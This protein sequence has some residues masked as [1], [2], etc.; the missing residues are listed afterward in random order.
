[1]PAFDT[2]GPTPL[3][4]RL[5]IG[6]VRVTASDRADTLV[7]VAPADPGTGADVRAAERIEVTRTAD[8]ISV[9]APRSLSSLG[10]RN[11]GSVRVSVDLPAGSPVR[12]RTEIA[13]L[14]CEGDL[15]HCDLRTSI[16]DV[17]VERARGA[18]LASGNGTVRVDHVAGD[19]RLTGSDRVRVGRVEGAATVTGLNGGIEIGEVAGELAVTSANGHVHVGGA[20]GRA[21]IRSSNGTVRVDEVV[22]D[23][24][25]LRVGVGDIEVG[26]RRATA[27]W[28]DLD[29]R[30]GRVHRSLE[31][32][33]GPDGDERTVRVL[34][35]TGVG[36]ITVH[37]A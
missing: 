22:R 33:A 29:T 13:D 10:S 11:Q 35:R 18:T 23:E 3:V 8:G 24:V 26:V 12:A 37:P 25:T 17:T 20:H 14:L 21:E 16:G 28:L 9:R 15:G 32:S 6:T 31:D 30:L 2:P 34:A 36:D 19:L 7:E 1:M 5:E 4:L 27:A